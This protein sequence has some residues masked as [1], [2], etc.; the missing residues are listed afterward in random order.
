MR[1]AEVCAALGGTA[2]G[3]G[4]DCDPNPCDC[5]PPTG[6]CCV[7]ETC[8]LQTED[9]CAAAGGVYFPDQLTCDPPFS[10]PPVATES[11]TWGRIK[12]AYR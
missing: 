8:L 5:P 4:S 10:C 12:A 6:A 9:E 3:P 11:T 2:Q 1:L 7:G